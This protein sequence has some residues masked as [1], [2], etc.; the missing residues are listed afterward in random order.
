M[1][2]LPR[3]NSATGISGNSAPLRRIERPVPK[4]SAD[5]QERRV[6]R[7]SS[8]GPVP[9][10]LSLGSGRFRGVFRRYSLVMAS[11]VALLAVIGCLWLALSLRHEREIT[12]SREKQWAETIDRLQNRPQEPTLLAQAQKMGK[13]GAQQVL[14]NSSN[15][16]RLHDVSPKT[17]P[18]TL[19]PLVATF[20]LMTFERGDEGG[21]NEFRIP[22]AATR[23]RL[24]IPLST[25]EYKKYRVTL[26][27]PEGDEVFVGDAELS[28]G[29]KQ[30]VIE[31]PV[32]IL[33]DG[34]YI[35]TVT[36]AD[37]VGKVKAVVN[38]YAL[39][40]THLPEG[41]HKQALSGPAAQI[42]AR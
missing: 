1:R 40:F 24:R 11:S 4:N 10:Y 35:L 31:T 18:H 25:N 26:K 32:S 14:E 38:S 23:A 5:A 13:S 36:G 21:I 9:E 30:V 42:P 33:P 3:T 34:E 29:G 22:T 16:N 17:R 41:R 20:T 2:R 28:A 15:E 19:R 6:W 8:I 37:S 39:R 7:E 27:K 12:A